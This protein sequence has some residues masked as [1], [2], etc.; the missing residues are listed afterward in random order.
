MTLGR[1]PGADGLTIEIW[2]FIFPI[3]GEHFTRMINVAKQKMKLC[4]DF[5]N[6]LLTLLKKDGIYN[7][8]MKNFRPLSL[9]NIDYKILPKVLK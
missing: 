2:R 7:G 1:T 6:A 3:I 5:L 9:M 8:S 4:N